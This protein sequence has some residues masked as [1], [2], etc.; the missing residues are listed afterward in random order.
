[1]S[2]ELAITALVPVGPRNIV[3]QML[4]SFFGYAD[5][6][7]WLQVILVHN[8]IWHTN[9]N[10]S[11]ISLAGARGLPIEDPRPYL[12]IR[13]SVRQVAKAFDHVQFI[14]NNIDNPSVGH[15][16]HFYRMIMHSV[17]YALDHVN[18]DWVFCLVEDD[19]FFSPHWDTAMRSAARDHRQV[20]VPLQAIP[21]PEQFL[22]TPES[23]WQHRNRYDFRY[24]GMQVRER[25]W[26]N[27]CKAGVRDSCPVERA[28]ENLLGY[29]RPLLMR[30][31]LFREMGGYRFSLD[32]NDES[33]ELIILQQLRSMGIQKGVVCGAFTMHHPP[34]VE[35]DGEL[36]AQRVTYSFLPYGTKHES[37]A[38]MVG[39]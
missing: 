30:T 32:P 33:N 6:P 22:I 8:I 11:Y 9:V 18:T 27:Y 20:Y 14:E 38:E 26:I 36:G 12:T 10:P 13:E 3:G 29:S 25:E 5:H 19:M 35:L 4:Q 17:N 15:P 2:Q 24:P 34:Q 23:V 39:S 31:D 37:A 16:V 7:E 21:D 1:M 28:D